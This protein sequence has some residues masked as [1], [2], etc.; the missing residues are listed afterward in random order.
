M[1]TKTVNI[2]KVI[3]TT[4]ISNI[5][6]GRGMTGAVKKE[7]KKSAKLFASQLQG[8]N[9]IG[10]SLNGIS[11]TLD[12]IRRLQ[13][14]RLKALEKERIKDSFE[15]RYTKNEKVKGSFAFSSGVLG[16][17]APDFFGGLMSFLGGLIKYLVLRPIL[18]WLADENNQQKIISFMEGLKKVL[19]FFTWLISSAIVN[20]IEGLYELLRDDA[21]PW[22]RLTGFLK[23]FGIIGAAF[24]GL[25]FLKNPRKTIEAFRNVFKNFNNNL[26]DRH[27]RLKQKVAAGNNPKG[28][29]GGGKKPVKVNPKTKPVPRTKPNVGGIIPRIFRRGRSEGGFIEPVAGNVNTGGGYI[30]GPMGGYPVTLDGKGVDFIGHGREF[31]AQKPGG[32]AFVIPF[33]TPDT[34]KN[35]GLTSQRINEALKSGYNLKE[36]SK[37]GWINGPESGYLAS[38]TGKRPEFIGHGLEYISKDNVGNSYVIPFNSSG[39]TL[40]NM[41]MAHMAGFDLPDRLPSF[42]KSTDK[43]PSPRGFKPPAYAT[44]QGAGK[45]EMFFGSI[46]KAIGGLFGGGKKKSGGGGGGGFFSNIISG[47]GSFLGGAFG[48]GSSAPAGGGMHSTVPKTSGLDFGSAFNTGGYGVSRE[49]EN[50]FT[51]GGGTDFMPKFNFGNIFGGGEKR[52]RSGDETSGFGPLANGTKYAQMVTGNKLFGFDYN[53]DGGVKGG[54]GGI[55]RGLSKQGGALGSMIG[56]LFG[57]KGTGN[58]IGNFFQTIMGGGGS[59]EDGS[60]NWYDVIRGGAGVAF[61]FLK[62][63]KIFGRDA[64]DFIN[65]ATNIGDLL[66]RQDGKTFGEKL[67]ELVARGL[68]LFGKQN[69]MGGKLPHMLAV[70]MGQASP[71]SLLTEGQQKMLG[72]LAGAAQ[73]TDQYGMEGATGED[74]QIALDGAGPNKAKEIGQ[75]ALTRGLT[76]FNNRFFR[77]NNWSEDGPNS[78][79]FSPGG[80]EAV[81]ANPVHQMGLAVDIASYQGDDNKQKSAMQSFAESLYSARQ[82]LKLQSIMY[83]DWGAWQYGKKR[84][85]PGNYGIPHLHVAVA[86]AKV[87]NPL[88]QE[89]ATGEGGGSSDAGQGGMSQTQYQAA[90]REVESQGLGGLMSGTVGGFGSTKYMDLIKNFSGLGSNEADGGDPSTMRNPFLGGGGNQAAA[91][92]NFGGGSSAPKFRM[93][94]MGRRGGG[95]STVGKSG[96]MLPVLTGLAAG[97]RGGGGGGV[98]EHGMQESSLGRLMTG[99]PLMSLFGFQSGRQGGGAPLAKKP[100]DDNRRSKYEIMKVTRE[101]AIARAE[102]N[103]RSQQTVQQ[104]MAAVEQANA[105]VR[106]SVAAAQSAIA[107]IGAGQGSHGG[108]VGS[109]GQRIA[110][111]VGTAMSQILGSGMNSGGGL[112]G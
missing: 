50:D 27:N 52:Y 46:G 42:D 86:K 82:N 51:F 61:Q 49:F 59:N 76:V 75:D 88:G 64:Q 65:G 58:A 69:I 92:A 63:K 3:P 37:G 91:A 56:G 54:F 96:G 48:G 28:T 77:R 41:Q 99:S 45:D 66:F 107:N 1:E 87:A 26:T 29:T 70:A 89:A 83:D 11:K 95:T 71:M 44:S 90:K 98:S 79:G 43:S 68:H 47:V 34:I 112:F 9:Q 108:A 106:A 24:V 102:M 36:M 31:V 8:I 20:I 57:A 17:L 21:T 85:S 2:Y 101:R 55:I 33:E 80:R 22:E 72:G 30:N 110:Q 35:P 5:S 111:S 39:T 10:L 93:P 13:V 103:R 25:S 105:S 60:A 104:T 67:P 15:A 81:S 73:G 84:K 16:R 53:Q 40:A 18:E 14:K 74:G 94:S 97:R 6:F 4:G 7:Q 19:D 78:K 109:S 12:N 62:G 23:A 38:M 32:D 100:G